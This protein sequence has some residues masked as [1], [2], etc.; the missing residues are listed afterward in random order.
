MTVAEQIKF[1]RKQAKLTQRELSDL[2]GIAEITIRQYEAGK[3]SPKMD[4]LKK[5]ADAFHVPV[6]VMLDV[7]EDAEILSMLEIIPS[8]TVEDSENGRKYNLLNL[9]ELFL[10]FTLNKKGKAKALDYISDLSKL[11]EYTDEKPPTT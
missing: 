6:S 4:N 9:K 3:Y 1:L 2:S 11:P 8:A 7:S 5:L 10:Y